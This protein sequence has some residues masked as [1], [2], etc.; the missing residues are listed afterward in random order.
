VA[1]NLT[2]EDFAAIDAV[3]LPID[4]LLPPPYDNPYSTARFR[5][6][7]FAIPL[8]PVPLVLL[9]LRMEKYYVNPAT[10]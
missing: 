1:D 7:M 5:C 3:A 9:D 6:S 4:E 2:A 10:G 8:K